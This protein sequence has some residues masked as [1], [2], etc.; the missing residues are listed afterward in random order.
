MVGPWFTT[1][2]QLVSQSD[3]AV[4]RRHL[5]PIVPWFA[6]P[7]CPVPLCQIPSPN[8]AHSPRPVF[9]RSSGAVVRPLP[10][11]LPG[12]IAFLHPSSCVYTPTRPPATQWRGPT[13]SSSIRGPFRAPCTGRSYPAPLCLGGLIPTGPVG[14]PSS[15]PRSRFPRLYPTGQPASFVFSPPC[16]L[17]PC[18]T[19]LRLLFLPRAPIAPMRS[20][21]A[22]LPCAVCP[23]A[24][25]CDFIGCFFLPRG[26]PPHP[27]PSV[28]PVMWIPVPA[29]FVFF[30]PP[31]MHAR[32]QGTGDGVTAPLRVPLWSSRPRRPYPLAV[33]SQA[34]WAPL[35]RVTLLTFLSPLPSLPLPHHLSLARPLTAA[36]LLCVLSA[37]PPRAR[38]ESPAPSRASPAPPCP[39]SRRPT[40]VA[41]PGTPSGGFPRRPPR[42]SPLHQLPDGRV[43]R[44]VRLNAG[45]KH[46]ITLCAMWCTYVPLLAHCVPLSSRG[47]APRVRLHFLLFASLVALVAAHARPACVPCSPLRYP[48]PAAL[49]PLSLQRLLSSTHH[50]TAFQPA[51]TRGGVACPLLSEHYR[52]L[53]LLLLYIHQS[54]PLVDFTYALPR[55]PY[56]FSLSRIVPEGLLLSPTNV[57]EL[58]AARCGPR[59]VLC[60]SS[61][62]STC[63]ALR[64]PAT[65]APYG[66]SAAPSLVSV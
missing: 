55:C 29:A 51:V 5:S 16:R 6:T 63:R 27:F 23:P 21:A 62:A 24:V 10:H 8:T 41:S 48:C 3:G 28:R 57:G 19:C 17:L 13:G 61:L 15:Q 56:P 9:S 64:A 12:P 43:G 26:P 46:G 53:S 4:T 39:P 45:H 42:R 59:S 7:R 30:P 40:W 33:P 22:C 58:R 1:P 47:P 36:L 60:G 49:R 54:I 2:W 31:C 38:A 66:T 14:G 44:P 18:V 11:S 37:A 20:P 52:P 32:Y 50:L 25:H 65:H 34:R 35:P